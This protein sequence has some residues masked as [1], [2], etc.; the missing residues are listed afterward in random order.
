VT[1]HTYVYIYIFVCDL[2]YTY[3]RVCVTS[4]R[5]RRRRDNYVVRH[6]HHHQ[7][8]HLISIMGMQLF[9]SNIWGKEWSLIGWFWLVCVRARACVTFVTF[10]MVVC[11]RKWRWRNIKVVVWSNNNDNN[12]DVDKKGISV[13]VVGRGCGECDDL[14]TVESCCCCLWVKMPFISIPVPQISQCS[15]CLICK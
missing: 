13:V 5:R 8:H 6:R 14:Q 15:T 11:T 9:E 4:S 7:H 2:L 12:D 3:A 10:V 1:T